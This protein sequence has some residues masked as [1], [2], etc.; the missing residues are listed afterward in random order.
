MT[1]FSGFEIHDINQ[2]QLIWSLLTLL[3]RS[4]AFS[5]VYYSQTGLHAHILLLQMGHSQWKSHEQ[6]CSRS[7]NGSDPQVLPGSFLHKKEPGHEAIRDVRVLCGVLIVHIPRR[8]FVY[9]GYEFGVVFVLVVNFSKVPLVRT[10][11]GCV[12]EWTEN[13]NVCHSH[14]PV[15]TPCII[16]RRSMIVLWNIHCQKQYGCTVTIKWNFH[17]ICVKRTYVISVAFL[18]DKYTSI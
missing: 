8:W 2:E 13:R 15:H 7:I 5:M 3:R 17:S 1:W 11:F 9:T 12:E 6:W 18:G 14:V 16:F 10:V 4:A